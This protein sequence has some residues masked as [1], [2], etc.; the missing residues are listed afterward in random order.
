MEMRTGK[1]KVTLDD[2]GR[3]ELYGEVRNLVVIAPAGCYETWVKEDALQNL[4]DDLRERLDVYVW[5][6]AKKGK[7][8]M[9]AREAFLN[10]EAQGPRMLVMNIEALS[11]VKAAREVL[12]GFLDQGPAMVVIDESTCI[13]NHSAKRT[14]F[15]LD[16]VRPRAA[17]RR[18]LSGLP[19]PRD[20][21]DIY[22]QFYFL[23]PGILGHRKFTTFRAR[24]AQTVLEM[25]GGRRFIRVVGF[26]NQEEL[27][28]RIAD[29]SYRVLLSEAKEIPPK[30]YITREVPLTDEQ[31]RVYGQMKKLAMAQLESQDYVTATLA[32]TKILRLHQIVMGH[33]TDDD[34]KVHELPTHRITALLE[35][36]EEHAGKA[37]IWAPYDHTVNA[38]VEALEKRYGPG[39]VS[40]FWGG[41]RST[42]EEEERA[43][44]EDP[45]VLFMVAT[46]A[47]GGRGRTWNM[48]NLM[49]YVGNTNNLEHRS[50][51]E[52]R[53]SGYGKEDRV[54]V[55]D[56]VSPGTVEEKIIKAL[57]DK[58]DLASVITGDSW[59]EWI[60]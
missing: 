53:G 56:L 7:A 37:I 18:I 47:A 17:F 45:S 49:V 33:T 59:K 25:M 60:V 50:Q 4:S 30:A 28:S 34:G 10:R 46:A 19:T 21:L 41:N 5:R 51:S 22:A 44:K 52:E 48:A 42:R 57:R 31:K 29:N 36:L 26:K 27:R 12:I 54:T 32:I 35:V 13:K 3:L 11:T 15:V 23:D 39:T 24:Y 2:F 40:R 43:F 14:K 6:S 55:V 20:P 9:A 16:E 8:E 1:T 38:I 58:I